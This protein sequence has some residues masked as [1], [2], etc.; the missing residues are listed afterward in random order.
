M[1]QCFMFIL[2]AVLLLIFHNTESK[3]TKC[4]SGQ[5]LC[6]IHTMSFPL[7]CALRKQKENKLKCCCTNRC[8][9]SCRLK[10][11]DNILLTCSC[12]K[13]FKSNV[14]L[15]K[16]SPSISRVCTCSVSQPYDTSLSPISTL[17]SLRMTLLASSFVKR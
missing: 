9:R 17:V 7:T 16:L 1:N 11:S 14:L 6:T 2:F 5:R 15:K 13:L 10:S 3:T 12:N 8:Y 4:N